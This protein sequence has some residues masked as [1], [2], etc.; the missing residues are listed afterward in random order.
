MDTSSFLN[1]LYLI[2]DQVLFFWQNPNVLKT[3]MMANQQTL[4]E[5]L[6]ALLV[7][8]FLVFILFKKPGKKTAQVQEKSAAK[9]VETD[10]LPLSGQ[11][12]P[13]TFSKALLESQKRE[14]AFPT[15][16]GRQPAKKVEQSQVQDLT[17]EE[18]RALKTAMNIAGKQALAEITGE[19]HQTEIF[20][21]SQASDAAKKI[22][23]GQTHKKENADTD[24][25]LEN[26]GPTPGAFEFV[27]LYFMAPRSQA[28]EGEELF[29][30]LRDLG[31]RLN[32]AHVFE[33]VEADEVQFYVSSA[34]KPG[35][36]DMHRLN[37]KLPGVSFV[38]DLGALT[39]PEKS[40]QTMLTCIH[41]LSQI[42]KGDILD[43][44]HQ[45]LTQANIYQYMARIRSFHK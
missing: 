29:S 36:F 37:Y 41:E 2:R 33:Y 30:V 22:F 14:P 12:T 20:Q 45:R 38:L 8:I 19:P 7:L 24:L 17:E 21:N 28:F 25:G 40:F 13:K 1:K 11:P 44:F 6:L 5:F 26:A 39:Y 15:R 4:L 31:L 16:S 3:E 27:M 35:H 18:E 42:L 23:A 43:E 34:L 9:G 32:D 10:T